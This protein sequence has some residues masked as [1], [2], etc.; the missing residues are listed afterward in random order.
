MFVENPT[1]RCFDTKNKYALN[2]KTR[3]KINLSISET[4]YA[5][6][7][8]LNQHLVGCLGTT[9]LAPQRE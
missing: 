4:P 8:S 7:S 3:R 6:S 1:L 2:Y 5:P 9:G